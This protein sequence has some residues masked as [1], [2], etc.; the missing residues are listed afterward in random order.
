MLLLIFSIYHPSDN[1]LKAQSKT[2]T[3]YYKI[4]NSYIEDKT[5]MINVSSFI[6]NPNNAVQYNSSYMLE[7]N[8]NDPNQLGIRLQHKWLGIELAFSPRSTQLKN[9]GNTDYFGLH[10]F[11]YGRK[12]A[13]DVYYLSYTGYHLTNYKA[14]DTLKSAGVFPTYPSMNTNN[15]GGS[16]TYIFNHKK[17]SLRSSYFSNEI[18]KKSAGSFTVNIAYNNFSF[19]NPGSIVPSEVQ[20]LFNP[21][22][23]ISMGRFKSVSLIPAYNH[24]L[25]AWKRF[26]FTIGLGVGPMV[27]FISLSKM[28]TEDD[29]FTT[30]I[31]VRGNGRIAFGYNGKRFYIT[32]AGASDNFN[33]NMGQE[34]KISSL[35]SESRIT[36][37]FRLGASGILKKVSE[38]LDYIPIR[39]N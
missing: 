20:K 1:V 13:F 34:R 29:E 18:Q 14:F 24:T 15:W 26:F 4:R 30:G 25:V 8:P 21:S 5:N 12:M 32:A 9:R 6:R 37:G 36:V 23:V 28:T 11:S 22:A 27:Q 35:I 3:A 39:Y 19:S 31:S 16:F 2:D 17:F 38:L 10:L 7:L 33:Y